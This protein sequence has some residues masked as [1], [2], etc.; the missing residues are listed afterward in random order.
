[1]TIPAIAA[2]SEPAF[3]K[4]LDR[5]TARIIALLDSVAARR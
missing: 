4:T 5:V 1:M 3:E 2:L